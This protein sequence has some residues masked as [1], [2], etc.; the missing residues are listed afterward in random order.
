MLIWE[1][2]KSLFVRKNDLQSAQYAVAIQALAARVN[3]LY[4]NMD[5]R[6]ALSAKAAA[7]RAVFN[8]NDPNVQLVLSDLARFCR[9]GRS[10]YADTDRETAFRLGRQEVMQRILDTLACTPEQLLLQE[11]DK[12]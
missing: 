11:K 10:A 2:I 9:A 5:A 4:A 6:K 7:Y 3:A 12:P 1:L 8:K